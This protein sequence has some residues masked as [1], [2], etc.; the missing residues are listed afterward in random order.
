MFPDSYRDSIATPSS[1]VCIWSKSTS[2][3]SEKPRYIAIPSAHAQ[4]AGRPV[5][6][7]QTFV[8]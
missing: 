2:R 4:V 7:Y 8:S 1:D 5:N 6:M 3:P